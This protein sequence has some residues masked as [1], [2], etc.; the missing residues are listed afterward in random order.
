MGH[1]VN[2]R[3]SIPKKS[4][5]YFI[6]FTA[7]TYSGATHSRIQWVPGATFRGDIAARA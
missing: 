1:G 5:R 6:Y 4:K 3:D 2:G 7:Q